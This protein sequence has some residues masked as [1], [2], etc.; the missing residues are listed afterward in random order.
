M[1]RSIEQLARRQGAVLGRFGPITLDPTM[2]GRFE[3]AVAWPRRRRRGNQPVPVSLALVAYLGREAPRLDI[4]ERPRPPFG[5][6]FGTSM[7]G[8]TAITTFSPIHVGDTIS[9]ERRLVAATTKEGSSGLLGIVVVETTIVGLDQTPL[10]TAR[11][12]TVH[13]P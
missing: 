1:I 6:R 4:D 3:A 11:F 13:R 12:T 5:P 9:G 10:V 8:G 7:N 2:V